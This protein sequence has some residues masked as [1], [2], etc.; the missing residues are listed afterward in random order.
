MI[1]HLYLVY[2]NPVKIIVV[3]IVVIDFAATNVSIPPCFIIDLHIGFCS[4]SISEPE[5]AMLITLS[6]TEIIPIP[7]TNDK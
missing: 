3:K 4:V 7:N 2:T 5:H 6:Y 1:E